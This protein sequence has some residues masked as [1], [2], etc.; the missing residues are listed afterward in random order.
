MKM[1]YQFRPAGAG[2]GG[3]KNRTKSLQ[4]REG[5][6]NGLQETRSS[7]EERSQAVVRRRMPREHEVYV[8]YWFRK[9]NW[10]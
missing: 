2:G 7:C 10:Q 6:R 8:L 9:W 3:S 1:I 5:A 4:T